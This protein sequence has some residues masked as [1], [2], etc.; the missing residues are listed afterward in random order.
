M[1][2]RMVGMEGNISRRELRLLWI[3]AWWVRCGLILGV[4][5][6]AYGYLWRG[7]ADQLYEFIGCAI[8]ILLWEVCYIRYLRKLRAE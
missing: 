8:G 4:S 5:M 1:R 3:I 7:E 2:S 6:G